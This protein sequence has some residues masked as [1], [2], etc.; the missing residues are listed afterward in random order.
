VGGSVC[1]RC[2]RSRQAAPE[3]GGHWIHAPPSL[4]RTGGGESARHRPSLAGG[5]TRGKAKRWLGAARWIE[6]ER[7]VGGGGMDGGA[8]GAMD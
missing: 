7:D 3:Y 5:A 8:G 6:E 2:S 4:P 1:C